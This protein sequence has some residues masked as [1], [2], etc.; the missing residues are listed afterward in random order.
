M[1]QYVYLDTR[2]GVGWCLSCGGALVEQSSSLWS[3]IYDV[4]LTY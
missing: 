3:S 1:T 4:T 2:L